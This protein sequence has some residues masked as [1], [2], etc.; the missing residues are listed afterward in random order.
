VQAY[1]VRRLVLALPTFL[2]LT[3]LVFTLI[4]SI[5]GDTVD[6]MA[7]GG[8]VTVE[9]KAS[10]RHALGLDRPWYVQY[11]AW[12]GGLVHGNLGRSLVSGDSI[13]HDLGQRLPQSLELDML[14]IP[15]GLSIALPIGILA[16]LRQNTWLDYLGR[17][18]AIT[19][20]AIPNFWLG[21]LL[22]LVPS[23]LWH[24]APP[25]QYQTLLRDPL[26]NLTMLALPVLVLGIGLSGLSMRL[27]RT[28]MLEVMREDYVRTAWAKGLSTR[29]VL[30]RHAMRNALLPVVTLVG[31]QIPF[32]LGGTVV[33]EQIF[34]IPG[35]GSYLLL[36]ISQRDYPA[37]QAVD[38]VIGGVVIL[39]NLLVDLAYGFLDPRLRNL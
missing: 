26:T 25:L 39:S 28:Q 5:P 22:L 32:L 16:A 19:A 3:V 30:L 12:V 1:L 4:R 38:L 37:I 10:I 8:A 29:V 36:G 34:G 35:M 2:G 15:L 7:S 23:Y 6:Q 20:L 9:G 13:A 11:G 18:S 21:T 14:A 17:S 33:V 24:I 31:L 27:C